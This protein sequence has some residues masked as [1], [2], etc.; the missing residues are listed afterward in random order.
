MEPSPRRLP[1]LGGD[2]CTGHRKTKGWFAVI[3]RQGWFS[4]VVVARYWIPLT[5][6]FGKAFYSA[7][8]PSWEWKPAQSAE[9]QSKVQQYS[10]AELKGKPA[11][12]HNP[13][14]SLN[15]GFRLGF[16]GGIVQMPEGYAPTEQIM[17]SGM[18]VYYSVN[19]LDT[20]SP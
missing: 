1:M 16:G 9:G 7:I 6:F 19:S 11:M 4:S 8:F 17:G 14:K 3:R 2:P 18:T 10:F 13:S 20:V 15:L 12:M 5:I